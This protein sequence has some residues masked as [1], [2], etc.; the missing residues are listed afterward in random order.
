ML[1]VDYEELEMK[2]DNLEAEK[3]D[4]DDSIEELYKQI[5]HLKK[6]ESIFSNGN[7]KTC[8]HCTRTWP[9]YPCIGSFY[10]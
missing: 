4:V 7:F 10:T 3:I 2:N 8:P 9:I 1:R 5:S 6:K